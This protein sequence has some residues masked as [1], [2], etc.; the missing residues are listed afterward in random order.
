M[1]GRQGPLA[2]EQEQEA[3]DKV[4]EA[5]EF[6][7]AAGVTAEGTVMETVFG[8]AA[9]EI[10]EQAGAHDVAVI[11]M[12]SRGHSEFVSLVVGST[13]HKVLHL[14]DRPVLVVT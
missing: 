11:I 5:V 4:D 13:A 10:V 14:S 12:G 9:R 1:L 8:H 7:R 3:H 2:T 6:L